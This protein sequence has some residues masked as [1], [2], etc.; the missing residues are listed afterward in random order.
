MHQKGQTLFEIVTVIA[1][2]AL[3][4]TV[5]VKGL[6][7]SLKNSRFV[8]E[9]SMA[10]NYSNQVMEWLI[11][12]RDHSWNTFTGHLGIYCLNDLSWDDLT[13]PDLGACQDDEFI[14]G[15]NYQREATLTAVG[16]SN[17]EVEVRVEVIWQSPR[18]Q[19]S[20]PLVQNLT[21]WR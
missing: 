16:E 3:V 1:V 6:T 12:Q 5:L 7:L 13:W 11:L 14:S 17:Q 21:D 8:R 20:Y 15:T 9:K 10:R 19:E 4:I 18:G 2:I